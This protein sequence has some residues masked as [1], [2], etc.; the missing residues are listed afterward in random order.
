MPIKI[1]NAPNELIN[2]YGGGNPE[3][4][5]PYGKNNIPK[6]P[7]IINNCPNFTLYLF[8]VYISCFNIKIS[9]FPHVM[10]RNVL[11]VINIAIAY[12]MIIFFFRIE[13]F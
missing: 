7:K 4:R 6:S 13:N 12:S 10:I 2:K 8:F 9:L 11:I 5:N 1:K 3:I